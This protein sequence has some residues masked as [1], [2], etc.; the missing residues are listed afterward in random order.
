MTRVA[1][2]EAAASESTDAWVEFLTG[3][4]STRS[5]VAASRRLRRSAGSDLGDRDPPHR[6][7][8]NVASFIDCEMQSANVAVADQ[9]TFK[10]DYWQVFNGI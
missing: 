4:E 9:D 10:S 7:C 3:L 8:G 6:A 5:P 1:V 2:L